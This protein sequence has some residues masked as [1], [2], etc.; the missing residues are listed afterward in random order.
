MYIQVICSTFTLS[1]C[2]VTNIFFINPEMKIKM[3]KEILIA[4]INKDIDELKG[5]VDILG[6]MPRIS[7]DYLQLIIKK[8]KSLADNLEALSVNLKQDPDL[9]KKSEIKEQIFVPDINFIENIIA[10]RVS[11]IF[12]SHFDGL[13][14]YIDNL[15]DTKINDCHIKNSDISDYDNNGESGTIVATEPIGKSEMQETFT[16]FD[17]V[18]SKEILIE[19]DNAEEEKTTVEEGKV[20]EIIEEEETIAEQQTKPQPAV[21]DEINNERQSLGDKFSSVSDK[22]LAATINKAKINDL[23]S[24]ITIADRFRFQRELFNGDGEKTNKSIADFN[25][26]TTMDEAREYIEKHFDWSLDNSAVADFMQL[27]ERRYL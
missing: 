6:D 25:T 27:L 2:K 20:T 7:D 10:N 22:S 23:K 4:L 21:K 24:A 16:T 11:E 14:S 8:S 3:K 15:I 1:N 19:T 12:T 5:F 9:E 17:G 26:F 13:K 18:V